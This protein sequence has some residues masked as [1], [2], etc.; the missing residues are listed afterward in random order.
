MLHNNYTQEGYCPYHVILPRD[1]ETGKGEL[2][3]GDLNA[4]R[5][6]SLMAEHGV[7]TIITAAHGLE[8]LEI[9]ADQTHIVLPLLDTKMDRMEDYFHL[10]YLTIEQSIYPFRQTSGAGQYSSTA[11]QAS[12]E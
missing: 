2:L 4:A 5:D 10:S 12:P 6:R 9:P 7:R 3:L 11:V 1:E 8:K